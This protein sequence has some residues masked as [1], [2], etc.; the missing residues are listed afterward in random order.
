MASAAMANAPAPTINYLHGTAA[1]RNDSNLSARTSAVMKQALGSNA[2]FVPA[3]VPGGTA[4]DDFSE[5]SSSKPACHRSF[6]SLGAA[7]LAKYK[8]E[9]KPVPVNRSPYFAPVPEPTIRIGVEVLTLAVLTKV[10]AVELHE[11]A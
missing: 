6:S 5:W 9:N 7:M 3:S 2:S 10:S 8:A 1:V 4:S 11:A